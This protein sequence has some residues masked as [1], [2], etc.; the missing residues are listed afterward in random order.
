VGSA[1]AWR[2]SRPAPR[3]ASRPMAAR[4]RSTARIYGSR[5]DPPLTAGNGRA[6]MRHT[7]RNLTLLSLAGGFTALLTAVPAAEKG[8]N[9][10][11]TV[12]IG[13]VGTLFRDMPE[14]LVKATMQPFG[15]LMESQTGLAGQ[16]EPVGDAI[17]LGRMLAEDQ[18][19]LGVFHGLEFAWAR[20]KY[21]DLRPL[22]IA[23]NQQR[24]L[25]A[26]VM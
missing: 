16:L 3:T 8:P 25:W 22:M 11:G 6:M 14:A 1:P 7:R 10:T 12:R 23:V 21:P 9:P 24:H 15:A 26:V 20:Q 17:H 2:I 4:P 5:T 13:M 18:V 19:H